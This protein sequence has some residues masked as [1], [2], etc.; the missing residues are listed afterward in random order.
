MYVAVTKNPDDGIP[1]VI[2]DNSPDSGKDDAYG[3]GTDAVV[4]N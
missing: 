1:P 2:D 4:H 3:F